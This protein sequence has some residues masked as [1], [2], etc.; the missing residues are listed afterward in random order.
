MSAVAK[1]IVN[2]VLVAITFYNHEKNVM[3]IDK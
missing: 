1:T 3:F 2:P